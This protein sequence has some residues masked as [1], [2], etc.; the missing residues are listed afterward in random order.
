MSNDRKDRVFLSYAS[1][2]LDTVRK[3]Y[4]GLKNRGLEVWFDKE[5]LEP[6]KWKPQITRAITK[7]RYFIICLSN[8]AIR[9]TGDEPGFQDEELNDDCVLS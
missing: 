4:D 3:V 5:H 1:E 2:N 9:K 8:D 7:S 6:G